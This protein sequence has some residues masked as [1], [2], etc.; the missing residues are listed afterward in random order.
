MQQK[1]SELILSSHLLINHDC[2][3]QFIAMKL[4]IFKVHA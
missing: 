2:E 4:F 3:K 1:D